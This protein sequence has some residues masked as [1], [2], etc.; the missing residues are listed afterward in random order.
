MEAS[1]G[2]GWKSGGGTLPSE[3]ARMVVPGVDGECQRMF[4]KSGL[5]GKKLNNIS[6]HLS[7]WITQFFS[8]VF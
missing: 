6:D 2:E 5:L 7:L 3:S 1:P 4:S 8:M